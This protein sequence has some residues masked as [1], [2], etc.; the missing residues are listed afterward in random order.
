[1]NRKHNWLSFE[2]AHRK[3]LG[4]AKKYK[5]NSQVDWYR[6]Y[7]GSGLKPQNIPSDPRKIYNKEWKG[8]GHWLGTGN[9]P[10]WNKKRIYRVNDNYFKK[11]SHNMAYILGFW[12]ADGWIVDRRFC[13][14][15]NKGDE[16]ILK[17]ILKEMESNY[18]LYG[19]G[20][21][22][23]NCCSFQISSKEIVSDIVKLG[24]M[25]KKS[26]IIKFPTKIPKQYL[27]D[28]IRG[29]WDGD[30]CISYNKQ[31]KYYVSNF[32]S[33][34]EDFI[35]SFHNILK[36]NILSLSGSVSKVK[37]KNTYILSFSKNDTIRLKEFMYADCKNVLKLFRK[38]NIF[39]K[40]G[41]IKTFLSFKKAKFKTRKVIK[42]LKIG[43]KRKWEKCYK[44][45]KIPKD[46]PCCPDIV[47]KDRGWI[48]WYDWLGKQRFEEKYN[49][50]EI[51]K[52][53]VSG[54]SS[55]EIARDYSI[56]HSYVIKMLKKNHINIR[57]PGEYKTK[58]YYRKISLN[59]YD[60]VVKKY[61]R[62]ESSYAIAKE[63]SVS[64]DTILRTLKKKKIKIRPPGRRWFHT[65]KRKSQLKEKNN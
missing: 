5:L 49:N 62:G 12:F 32:V 53:Y 58:N 2:E 15:Q 6:G 45:K 26:L 47:Y 51:I 44:L 39:K 17:E 4:D 23:Y 9:K 11:R 27:L 20:N 21:R 16:Y 50:E 13:L 60:K 10:G 25:P 55:I 29:L 61:E 54:K 1:M 7:S 35:C 56:S 57:K 46:I 31:K 18:K 41:K 36:E 22:N 63:Y 28:F 19:N 52:K 64:V 33:G 38:Y 37:E 24:G 42:E 30:G 59:E 34:S 43:S 14:I 40:T 3:V 48:D 8:W 65:V